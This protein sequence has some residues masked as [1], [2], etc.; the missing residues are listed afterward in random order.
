MSEVEGKDLKEPDGQ[1][2]VKKNSMREEEK[3]EAARQAQEGWVGRSEGPGATAAI[4]EV[5][6]QMALAVVSD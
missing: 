2:Q 4:P 5:K 6:G 3:H 1:P